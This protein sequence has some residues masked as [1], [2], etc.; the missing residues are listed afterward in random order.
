MGKLDKKLRSRK[1]KVPQNLIIRFDPKNP[2]IAVKRILKQIH[3]EMSEMEA[4]QARILSILKRDFATKR[5]LNNGKVIIEISKPKNNKKEY[6][7]SIYPSDEAENII[8]L[9]SKDHFNILFHYTNNLTIERQ[10]LCISYLE[11]LE[12]VIKKLD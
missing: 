11:L 7:E 3:K 2:F 4:R 10:E 12:K 1:I 9:G 5:K 6:L 8:E